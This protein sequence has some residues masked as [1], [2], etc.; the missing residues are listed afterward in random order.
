MYPTNNRTKL[1]F[2]RGDLQYARIT[3]G[4]T[5]ITNANI[6]QGGLTINRYVATGESLTVGS[7]VAA[8][9]TLSLNNRD[10]S[11][12]NFAFNG[13]E[14]FVEFGVYTTSTVME[15]VTMGYFIIDEVKFERNTVTVTALDR[16]TLFDVAIDA[17][18]FT[19]PYTLKTLLERICTICGVT[20]G[21]TDNFTNY[22]YSVTALPNETKTYRDLLRWI[23]ELS[24][25]NGFIDYDG[26]LY[27]KWYTTAPTATYSLTT[28]NRSA[29]EIDEN[30]FSLTGVTILSDEQRYAAGTSTRPI[31]IRDNP[32]AV[33]NPQTLANN[34]NSVVNGFTW[35]PFSATVCPA[36]YLFPLD[37]INF[38]KKDGTTVAVSITSVTA[39]LNRYTTIAGTGDTKHN[40]RS[41]GLKDATFYADNIAAGAIT[42][43]KI[44]ASAVSAD[45][46]ATGTITVGNMS[47]DARAAMLNEN[48]EVGGRN[49]ALRTATM[50]TSGTPRWNP[51]AD[52]AVSTVAI[53]NAP[54]SGLTNAIRVT[55]ATSA[56]ARCGCSSS[57][58][59][60][61][62]VGE[63]YTIGCWV[64]ASVAGLGIE[65]RAAWN[66]NSYTSLSSDYTTT[67]TW[68]YVKFEG[69]AMTGTQT[70]SYY[71]GFVYVSNLPADGWFEVCGMKV[72]AGNKAT[73]WSAAPE[74]A[75]AAVADAYATKA[76][77][78]QTT[79]R[80]Y[81]RSS[82]SSAPDAPAT[83][84][85]STSTANNTW[86]T[87]RMKY[88]STYKYLWT[89]IQTKAVN[90]TVTNSTVLL[91]DTTTVID[92]GSITTG[93][94]AANRIDVTDLNAFGAT[95]A[96]W[97][98]SD[99]M[100][101][102]T[103]TL[104]GY[105]Y[106]LGMN[107]PNNPTASNAAFFVQR[108]ATG[109][110]DQYVNIFSARYDG[111]LVATN[112]NITGGSVSGST[113]GA[114]V[115]AGNITTGTLSADRIGAG[116][117][118]TT[119]IDPDDPLADYATNTGVAS[120]YETKTN[121]SNTYET[122]SNASSTYETKTNASNTYE[123]K[124]NASNTYETKTNAS[125]TYETKT[126]A[127][128]TYAT[129]AAAAS[130]NQRI[131]YRKSATGAPDAPATWIMST[132]TAN[133]T[134]TT[135]RMQ[136]DATYKYLYTCIQTKTVSGDV[137]NST[138]LLDDTT[139]VIDGGSITTGKVAANR[140][141]VNDLNAFGAT[142]AGWGLSSTQISKSFTID[143]IT[144]KAYMQ[145][146]GN[147]AIPSNGAFVIARTEDGTTTYPFV[148]RY[149]GKVEAS[150]VDISGKITTSEGE[151]AGWEIGA[152]SLSK[153]YESNSIKYKTKL[154][155]GDKPAIEIQ[156]G[157]N[158]DYYKTIL[159]I[160][161][162]GYV[163]LNSWS[164][165]ELA[166]LS[167]D[168]IRVSNSVNTTNRFSTEVAP[169][170]VEASRTD[171]TYT[172]NLGTK[173]RE[174]STQIT[175]EG[176]AI[177]DVVSDNY[178]S[179]SSSLTAESLIVD[180]RDMTTLTTTQVTTLTNGTANSGSGGVYYEYCGHNV[181]VH[182][183]VTSITADTNVTIF[184]LPTA[185]RPA[186]L[187]FSLGVGASF[188]TPQVV[189]GYINT[190]GNVIVR[191][192]GTAA[193]IDFSYMV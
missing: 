133:E 69:S 168:S 170:G 145:A 12:N 53:S 96:N 3:I 16:I 70:A 22:S 122:K 61:L 2:A 8:E 117:I 102:K 143:G 103:V 36:P 190:S 149:N 35:T 48:I 14:A 47:S 193:R 146:K 81:Y 65:L 21:T 24:G 169:S 127:Q 119:K 108:R 17:T 132:S 60:G 51:S 79:Q 56:A 57:A 126:N 100:I 138:V 148:A 152:D 130:T 40:G 157:S 150:N 185:L 63:Q 27:I 116:T 125:N 64:R 142:I 182:V 123:T 31:L 6:V 39:T 147:D 34:I 44:A 38:T 129:K 49:L 154:N 88:D 165:D 95:I 26:K 91:D 80:V 191:A 167:Y 98:L 176:I 7:C 105:D 174:T 171:R 33:T 161:Q 184:T 159:S 85:T 155:A 113:V 15:Y 188:A 99:N 121:A 68:Q 4:T 29:S 59:S 156:Q 86:T 104:D 1:V 93:K 178:S 30:T 131:Y 109:T 25:T 110:S 19:F 18:Q 106:R 192:P 28:A 62:I 82:S 164:E 78:S 5:V 54:I 172:T 181:H 97:S 128:S 162:T 74:D 120:T 89:C 160:D 52:A 46:I 11:W 42:A 186:T 163:V 37:R 153:A 137:S 94:V 135:K 9:M 136:Y 187:I 134:W 111:T 173:T 158:N 73:A 180:G 43:D 90:G 10:G 115:N 101:Y 92:G 107:A 72:E 87:K 151:I 141:D 177:S 189:Q 66:S 45:K 140:V 166:I 124:T 84:I 144:Y 23:C 118:T 71:L 76:D 67:T 55:N 20:L 139:T 41:Y 75:E 183:A 50:P 58:V 83:W 77:A 175:D 114:G 13:K 112:A 179:H 32:L